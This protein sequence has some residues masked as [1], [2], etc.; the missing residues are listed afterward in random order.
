MWLGGKSIIDCSQLS[1]TAAQSSVR[2][3]LSSNPGFVKSRRDADVERIVNETGQQK[4]VK[5]FFWSIDPKA[6]E[7]FA[8]K[9]KEIIDAGSRAK[10]QQKARAK[11]GPEQPGMLPV[12]MSS[13]SKP[14]MPVPMMAPR[15]MPGPPPPPVGMAMVPPL[16]HP[17]PPPAMQVPHM[18]PP[19]MMMH[20]GPPLPPPL[21]QPMMRPPPQLPPPPPGPSVTPSPSPATP[22]FSQALPDVCLSITVGPPPPGAPADPSAATSP[23]VDGPPI[24]LHNGALFLNPTIFSGLS[25]EQIDELQSFK[26]QKALEILMGYTKNYVKEQILK[27]GKAKAKSTTPTAP[28]KSDGPSPPPVSMTPSAPTTQPGFDAA[29][30][31]A[32]ANLA[33]ASAAHPPPPPTPMMNP[34]Q[35]YHPYPPQFGY[36][37]PPPPPGWS[38]PQPPP[39]LHQPPHY[40]PGYAFSQV[41][42]FPPTH[43]QVAGK[44]PLDAPIDSS[45]AAKKPKVNGVS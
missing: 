17:G 28:K 14:A 18:L 35:P 25:K 13:A 33:T 9:E 38:Y 43:V 19:P 37:P 15:G 32:V 24:T 21:P 29:S 36:P 16:M 5:G 41:P 45:V 20:S 27:K 44:H 4:K 6:E 40:P 31:L 3:N 1:L 10:A 7:S 11:E 42:Q 30:I 39:H 12:P 2:H 26:A 23:Y 8:E 22:A 34:P